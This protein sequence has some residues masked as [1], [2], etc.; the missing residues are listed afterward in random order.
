[1]LG[2][3]ESG[4]PLE[5][6]TPHHPYHPR[7][8]HG[9]P[10]PHLDAYIRGSQDDD[11]DIEKRTITMAWEDSLKIKLIRVVSCNVLSDCV[12]TC[13]FVG[14]VSR[15]PFKS[16]CKLAINVSAIGHTSSGGHSFFTSQMKLFGLHTVM[17]Y[18]PAW[19]M[20]NPPHILYLSFP[21]SP[22][23]YIWWCSMERALVFC[24]SSAPG[25]ERNMQFF[26]LKSS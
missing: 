9:R 11:P 6:T 1:M 20:H 2:L 17:D 22:D 8:W 3:K 23:V 19:H 10:C 14:Y 12:T 4:T 15:F 16:K 24:K 21:V 5:G 25:A 26:F 13:S 7:C 18:I